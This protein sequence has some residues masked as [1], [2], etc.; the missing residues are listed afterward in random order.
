MDSVVIGDLMAHDAF[1]RHGL[2]GATLM[3]I[4]ALH[5]RPDQ[6]ASQLAASSSVSRTAAY[7]TLRR[8][9]EAGLVRK[10][11]E[12]WALTP[13]AL[14]GVGQQADDH[15]FPSSEATPA[16]GWDDIAQRYGTA[17]IGARRKALHSAE[18][19]AYRDALERRA[20]RRAPAIV[21]VQGG[22]TVPAPTER[23]DEV[24]PQRRT[25]W[26]VSDGRLHDPDTGLT[27]PEWHVAT[28][29]RLIFRT[30]NDERSYDELVRAHIDAVHE[31]ES[32]A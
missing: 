19:A 24:T 32:A 2:G 31:W 15:A 23:A 21:V 3:V 9:A 16:Q 10:T 6:T 26:L 28:D 27:V 17:G 4:G 20:E 8:L 5:S 7:R 29:G 30:A 14:E 13:R 1:A 25:Q 12:T 22:R 11:A 18:P